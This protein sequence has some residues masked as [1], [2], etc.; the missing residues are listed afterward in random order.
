MIRRLVTDI[1]LWAPR[2]MIQFIFGV[3]FARE[4][5]VRDTEV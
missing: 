2:E 5:R 1:V 4:Y 3:G